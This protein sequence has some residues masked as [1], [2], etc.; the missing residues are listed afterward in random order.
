MS[1][2]SQIP[3]N[4]SSRDPADF[5]KDYIRFDENDLWELEEK[6]PLSQ[7]QSTDSEKI[8]AAMEKP[9]LSR[10][11][12]NSSSLTEPLDKT[13]GFSSTLSILEKTSLF[14]ILA[15][16]IFTATLAVIHFNKDIPIGSEIFKKVSLPVEGKI[17]SI[18]A[19][20]TYWR[21]P[22]T[23]GENPDTVRRGVKLIPS[24]KIQA[25]GTSGAIRIFFRN[26]EGTL[27]G[28]SITLAIT[29]TETPT[30]SATDGFTEMSMH[31]AYRTGATARWMVQ[32]LEG[33][34]I[35][36]PIEKFK[37]LFE[38]EISTDIR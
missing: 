24:I 18:S 2:D 20:E 37:T 1:N 27:V 36:A 35:D 21:K 7:D 10:D 6:S 16:L 34:A 13:P 22:N 11:L 31:A 23:E 33:P 3:E 32:V 4:P 8:Y 19:V 15:A 30:I 9:V 25:S 17:L 29:G 5:A 26:D 14:A 28:D 38:T 12:E